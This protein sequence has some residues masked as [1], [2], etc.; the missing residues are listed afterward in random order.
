MS[1]AHLCILYLS[2]AVN[3]AV[4]TRISSEILA[5]SSR[6]VKLAHVFQDMKYGRTSFF[7]VGNTPQMIQPAL[8]FCKTAFEK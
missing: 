1:S 7:I 5:Y 6:E 2:E 3:N 4:I 8:A